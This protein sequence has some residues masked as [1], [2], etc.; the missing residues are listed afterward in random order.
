MP[1]FI[2][3]VLVADKMEKLSLDFILLAL[4]KLFGCI[5]DKLAQ[6]GVKQKL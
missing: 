3:F 5:V 2:G 1:A 6:L 4:V